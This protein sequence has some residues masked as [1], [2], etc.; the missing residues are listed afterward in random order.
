MTPE[1]PADPLSAYDTRSA[2]AVVGLLEQA[3]AANLDAACRRGS[4]DVIEPIGTLIATG[5]LHDNPANLARVVG[6]ARLGTDHPAHLTLHEVIHSDRLVGGVDLSHRALLRVAALKAAN[7]EFV[8]TILANH[9]LAQIIGSGI[10]K[11]G[12]RVVEAFNNGVEYV[13]GDGAEIV[14]GAIDAFIR[15]MPVALISGRHTDK[16]LLCAHSLP[17][18]DVWDRFDPG[19]LD[20]PLTR[21]DYTPRQGSAHLITWG[22]RQKPEQL[23]ELAE[24]WGVRLFIL[25]HDHAETGYAFKEPNA[26]VLNSDH[27]K[28]VAMRVDL[29]K[30]PTPGDAG[31]CMVSLGSVP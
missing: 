16:G 28:G 20:R 6:L 17:G 12:V 5:D 11:D 13:F 21:D 19:V 27:A 18:P 4:A 31:E 26:I 15:S 1:P 24:R 3:A 30:P 9:E 8:H 29:A 14:L 25:G 2:P 23:T 10:V 7:P 22:R